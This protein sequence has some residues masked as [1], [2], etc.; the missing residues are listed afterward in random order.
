MFQLW[1]I[2]RLMV[3]TAKGLLF[4]REKNDVNLENKMATPYWRIRKNHNVCHTTSHPYYKA[5]FVHESIT[6]VLKKYSDDR[7]I[8]RLYKSD[9]LFS[10]PYCCCFHTVNALKFHSLSLQT[11]PETLVLWWTESSKWGK[12]YNLA[13]GKTWGHFIMFLL[14]PYSPW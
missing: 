11:K 5:L 7:D 3:S 2:K 12:M 1:V 13:K 14:S 9:D 10:Y 8:W 4:F 6:K